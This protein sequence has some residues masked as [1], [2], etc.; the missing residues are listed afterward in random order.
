[1]AGD[2][3]ILPADRCLLPA[4]LCEWPARQVLERGQERT[5]V[6]KTIRISDRHFPWASALDVEPAITIT[7]VAA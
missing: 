2:R 3:S 6:T 5:K 7:E 1:M 4:L